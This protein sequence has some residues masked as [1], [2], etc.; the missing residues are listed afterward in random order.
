[1]DAWPVTGGFVN[2]VIIFF[3]LFNLENKFQLIVQAVKTIY[4]NH[5]FPL[6]KQGIIKN[7]IPFV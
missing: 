5:R 2:H 3:T 6:I 4:I 7:P 1:M